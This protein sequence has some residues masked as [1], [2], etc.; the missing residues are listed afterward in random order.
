[1]YSAFLYKKLKTIVWNL[2]F[3]WKSVFIVT[4]YLRLMDFFHSRIVKRKVL[5]LHGRLNDIR[6]RM[7]KEYGRY[8]YFGGYYYQ[9]L[10]EIGIRG[11][12]PVD[13]RV[14]RYGILDLLTKDMNVLDIG[15]N[16]GF[17]ALYLSG[18]VGH[19]DGVE[20]NPFLVEISEETKRFL[21]VGNA[22]FACRDFVEFSTDKKYDAVFSLANH[23]TIDKNLVMDFEAYIKKIF[24]LL[25]PGGLMFFESHGLNTEDSDMDEKFDIMEKYFLTLRYKMLKA[26]NGLDIDRLFAVFK[27]RED[28]L[29]SAKSGFELSRALKKFDY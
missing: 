8:L 15:S 29:P 5:P 19:V 18:F 7:H 23:K 26:P 11:V 27:R 17:F 20:F 24:R 3:F 28:V 2:L 13:V 6:K 10:G 4:G 25:K 16:A 21:G 12:R 22:E 14:K 1:M 9:G